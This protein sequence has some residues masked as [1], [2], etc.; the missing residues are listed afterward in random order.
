MLRDHIQRCIDQLS[1]SRNRV[2]PSGRSG[3]QLGLNFKAR[4][5]HRPPLRFE[6]LES[7]RML[8]VAAIEW[9]Q[10]FSSAGHTSW[11]SSSYS[12]GGIYVGGSTSGALPGQTAAGP[13]AYGWNDSYVR[14]YDASG[15]ELWT[16][17]FG[18]FDP[19]GILGMSGDTSGI[20]VAGQ[21]RGALPGQTSLGSYDA[22]VRK[23]DGNGNELWTRQ[24][25]TIGADAATSISAH[26]SGI[27]VTGWTYDAF[28]GET[29]NG[30]WD[31]FLRKYD[32]S[33]NALWTRQFGTQFFDQGVS[34][35]ADDS[36]VYLTGVMRNQT[37]VRK[38]DIA[39]NEQWTNEIVASRNASGQ[40]ASP[41][42]LTVSG[43]SVYV[44]GAASGALVGE[45]SSGGSDAF[46]VKYDANGNHQ[47]SHQFGTPANDDASNVS[48][49]NSGVYVTGSTYGT[50]PGQTSAGGRDGYV[51][52]FDTSGNEVW[53]LQFGTP[54]DDIAFTASVDSSAVYVGGWT[55]GEFPGQVY[56][57]A[58]DAFVSRITTGSP[59]IL[60]ADVGDDLKSLVVQLDEDALDE[61]LAENP[62]N[63]R[64]TAANG[65]LDGNGNLFDD[66]NELQVAIDAIVYDVV[67]SRVTISY[68]EILFDDVFRL[69][70]DGDDVTSDGT[71][72]ITDLDGNFL[73]HGSFGY[74]LVGD[75]TVDF[76]LRPLSR[77]DALIVNVEDLGLATG[78]ESSLVAKLKAAVRALQQPEGNNDAATINSLTAF[79][80]ELKAQRGKKITESDADELLDDALF[81]IDLLENGLLA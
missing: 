62:S 77:L 44:S 65:D 78:T 18:T 3:G 69:E 4:T 59:L 52:K 6:F 20:Y 37:F 22:Y 67:E 79:I 55:R 14:K 15:D 61:A 16:H 28:P 24:F 19:D 46:L 54:A 53:T 39:G 26:A 56:L 48:F 1:T 74:P 73:A 10:Q 7:R 33:G 34:V 76:D 29:T 43:S 47:W 58:S 11:V 30:L 35:F 64:L 49:D 71:P 72:G 8:A 66:G 9:A 41:S 81:I 51:R 31:V 32:A 80:N 57:G 5:H 45:T 12:D 13:L 68:E 23:Y 50:L 38:Y 40:S 17:Q 25:G 36:G 75:F 2:N 70:I 21:V 27:Y 60:A 42:G 63:Y